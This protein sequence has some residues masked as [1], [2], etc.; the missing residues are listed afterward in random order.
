MKPFI[1]L[2]SVLFILA[3]SAKAQDANRRTHDISF[4]LLTQADEEERGYYSG[5][6]REMALVLAP[7]H[8]GPARTTGHSGLSTPFDSAATTFIR[9]GLIGVSAQPKGSDRRSRH[10]GNHQYRSSQGRLS[11][12]KSARV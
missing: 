12:S 10:D 5:V 3:P 8:L 4:G 2:L 1:A 7:L 6:A 9:N 11:A